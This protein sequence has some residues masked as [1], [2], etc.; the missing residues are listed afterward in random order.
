MG[1]ELLDVGHDYG[2]GGAGAGL[3]APRQLRAA[4]WRLRRSRTVS[5]APTTTFGTCASALVGVTPAHAN[6]LVHSV[7]SNAPPS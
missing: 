4:R 6:A 1:G 5:A 3:P 2:E 7:D